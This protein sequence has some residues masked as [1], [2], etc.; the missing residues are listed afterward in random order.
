[1]FEGGGTEIASE[2]LVVAVN[3]EMLVEITL[4]REPSGAVRA[5]VFAIGLSGHRLLHHQPCS[6]I[7]RFFFLFLFFLPSKCIDR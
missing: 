7:F 4:L 5:A 2:C 6:R 1:M 3:V